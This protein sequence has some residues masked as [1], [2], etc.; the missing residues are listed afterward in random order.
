MG[1]FQGCQRRPT[2]SARLGTSVNQWRLSS[3]LTPVIRNDYERLRTKLIKFG[4][5][6]VPRL[7]GFRGHPNLC[8]LCPSFSLP[9]DAS[10]LFVRLT[11][12]RKCAI[13]SVEIGLLSAKVSYCEVESYSFDSSYQYALNVD[14][15]V[16]FIFF[17]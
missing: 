13:K 5:D 15:M 10:N 2:G 11:N 7:S 17:L 4:S 16:E 9:R 12:N 3:L 1:P 6:F 14:R 8:L